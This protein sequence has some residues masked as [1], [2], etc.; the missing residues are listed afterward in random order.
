MKLIMLPTPGLSPVGAEMFPNSKQ[1]HF[2]PTNSS[3]SRA[4]VGTPKFLSYYNHTEIKLELEG[5]FDLLIV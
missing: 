1:M 2:H 4:K 5:G 3:S